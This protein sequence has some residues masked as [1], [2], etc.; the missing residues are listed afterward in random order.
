[1]RFFLFKNHCESSH[2][3]R[4]FFFALLSP[5]CPQASIFISLSFHKAF[6]P[7]FGTMLQEADRRRLPLRLLLL[8]AFHF[9]YIYIH[10]YIS[11]F[12]V[13]FRYSYRK[14]Y[15]GDTGGMFCSLP[16]CRGPPWGELRQAGWGPR[17]CSRNLRPP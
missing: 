4:S 6:F 7:F 11:Y 14:F 15:F 12:F 8:Y 3:L 13:C 5:G 9:L 10:V 2:F 17:L 1:M 16:V